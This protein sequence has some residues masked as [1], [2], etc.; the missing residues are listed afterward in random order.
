MKNY[1]AYHIED[2]SEI[3]IALLSVFP[4]ESFEEHDNLLIGYIAE[5]ELN[6]EVKAEIENVLGEQNADFH[7]NEI[8]PQNW[9]QLW[10]ESFQPVVVDDFCAVRADFHPENTNVRFDLIINPKMAFG[11][12]HHE[13]TYMM[14]KAMEDMEFKNKSV[15]DYGCGTGVLAVL[16]S[17]LGAN[18][19]DAIDIEEESYENSLENN[20]TNGV[21]NV[22]VECSDLAA[23]DAKTYDVI[24]AN[25]NRNVLL[26]SAIDLKKILNE[27]GIILLSGILVEDVDLVLDCYHGAGFQLLEKNNRG[28]WMCLKLTH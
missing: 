24:L 7:I 25:I 23:F 17:K 26:A 2:T 9:N 22:H 6:T 8:E 15:F 5:D 18:P 20:T 1:F 12:G 21:N 10:E 4:F 19:I 28:N 14:M 16:A 13:T 3:L 27:E 11:T